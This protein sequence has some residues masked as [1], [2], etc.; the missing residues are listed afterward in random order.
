MLVVLALPLI[1]PLLRFVVGRSD[2][3]T[4]D[5]EKSSASSAK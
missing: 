5:A 4:H 2:A 3:T 1:R